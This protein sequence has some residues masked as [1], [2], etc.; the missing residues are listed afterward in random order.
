MP[1]EPSAA[2]RGRLNVASGYAKTQM[3]T[4]PRKRASACH[5]HPA[6]SVSLLIH[7]DPICRGKLGVMFRVT[8]C[9]EGIAA[10]D[11]PAALADVAKEFISRPW[12]RIFD[13]RWEGDTLVLVADSDMDDDGEALAGEFSDTIAAYAP[14]TP[15]YRVRIL[16]VT[17]PDAPSSESGC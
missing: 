15:G 11:W 4:L 12:N 14:G 5:Q 2:P 13:C 10:K 17:V 1:C 8:V 3:D 16:S 7:G 6:R 9:C